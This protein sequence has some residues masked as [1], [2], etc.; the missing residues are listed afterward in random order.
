MAAVNLDTSTIS[1]LSKEISNRTISPVEIVEATLQRIEQLQPILLSFTTPTPEYAIEQARK[2]EKEISQ[3]KY[4]GP[5]HGIPYTLKDVIATKG[6]RT[7][8]GNP[9]G[10]DY[11]PTEDAT[12]HTL[13]EQAGAILVGKVVSEIGRDNTCLLY[14]SDAADE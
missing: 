1:V 3:G 13:L 8:F 7:T 12:L 10:T 9:K 14:T 11:K 2:A 4:R 5:L 6:I